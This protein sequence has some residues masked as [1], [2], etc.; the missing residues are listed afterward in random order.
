MR[1]LRV[2]EVNKSNVISYSVMEPLGIS[3]RPLSW[4]AACLSKR[5]NLFGYPVQ[6]GVKQSPFQH[7]VL[8]MLFERKII[9]N[10]LSWV[11]DPEKSFQLLAEGLACLC[12]S[13]NF[14]F[15]L[16]LYFTLQVPS[17]LNGSGE[18]WIFQ[19]KRTQEDSMT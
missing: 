7:S 12:Q 2:E 11:T 16:L 8:K 4:N 6:S 10:I 5:T 9:F 13:S 3:S 18:I 14:L 17:T 19:A 15:P 1:K